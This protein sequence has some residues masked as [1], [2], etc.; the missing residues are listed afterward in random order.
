MWIN[1]TYQT[2]RSKMP[3][4]HLVGMANTSTSFSMALCF[5]LREKQEDYEWALRIIRELLSDAVQ[6]AAVQQAAVLTDRELAL[7][8]AVEKAFSTTKQIICAWRINKNFASRRKKYFSVDSDPPVRRG[9][10]LGLSS[11]RGARVGV[12][13]SDNRYIDSAWL[14]PWSTKFCVMNHH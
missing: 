11:S 13:R 7:L 3:P 12:R 10:Y 1:A 9:P 8:N 14:A 6:Q 2:N 5:V 4:V